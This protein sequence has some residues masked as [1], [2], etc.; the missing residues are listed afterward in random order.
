MKANIKVIYIAI[1]ST[2]KLLI[3][4]SSFGLFTY[5]FTG[6]FDRD[7]QNSSWGE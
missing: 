1:F 5:A 4:S 7:D 6:A 3:L 2:G